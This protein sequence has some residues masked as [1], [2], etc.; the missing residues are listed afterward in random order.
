MPLSFRDKEP[1]T[2]SL[3][4]SAASSVAHIGKEL[5]GVMADHSVQWSWHFTFSVG[6]PGFQQHG[7]VATLEDAKAT[8]ERN[9]QLCLQA[10]GLSPS[11]TL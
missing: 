4:S 7:H 9:W 6:P 3:P 5:L 2:H 11:N 8:V 10:A 1:A